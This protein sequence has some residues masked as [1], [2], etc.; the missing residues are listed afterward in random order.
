MPLLVA[1]ALAAAALLALAGAQKVLDPTTTV[2]ALV[3]LRVPATPGLVRTGAAVELAIGVAAVT[4]GGPVPWALVAASYLAFSAFVVVALQRG[5]PIGSCGCFGRA[6]TPPSWAH[7]VVNDGWAVVAV[8]AAITL[9]RAP[10]DELA[11]RP[12]PALA[13]LAVA[14]AFAAASYAV[15]TRRPPDE[16]VR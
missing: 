9:D 3:A 14:A 10:L 8:A 16:I 6:D 1:P 13:A 11:D 12:G 4:V 5:T 15:Y 2:G 7:V